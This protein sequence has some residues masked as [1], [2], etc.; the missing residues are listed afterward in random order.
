MQKTLCG[1]QQT[2]ENL[3]GREYQMILPAFI[4]IC[5]QVKK[6]KVELN[7]EKKTGSK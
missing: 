2:V 1:S 6:Q 5:M 4:K 7:M 3:Q